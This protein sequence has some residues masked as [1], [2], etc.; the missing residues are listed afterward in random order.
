MHPLKFWKVHREHKARRCCVFG[1]NKPSTTEDRVPKWTVWHQ[2]DSQ[3]CV[4]LTDILCSLIATNVQFKCTQRM[5]TFSKA[6]CVYVSGG[7]KR[8]VF[9]IVSW[10]RGSGSSITHDQ[11]RVVFGEL[12]AGYLSWLS[13]P[14]LG[15]GL[16]V[17]MIRSWGGWRR[18]WRG[19]MRGEVI[20]VDVSSGPPSCAPSPASVIT[21][22]EDG[23]GL[24]ATQ[25]PSAGH[26]S[27]P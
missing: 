8:K 24:P 17:G 18:V 10:V 14:L 23:M 11:L 9:L 6:V 3:E 21:P 15:L 27:S 22:G 13:I 25:P 2:Q 19:V 5:Y 4:P 16:C 20:N 12:L 7:S 1:D 26:D